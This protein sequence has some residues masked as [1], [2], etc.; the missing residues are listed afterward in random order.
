MIRVRRVQE[1][2]REKLWKLI[3]QIEIGLTSL[4][5]DRQALDDKISRALQCFAHSSVENSP[6]YFFVMEDCEN[7]ELMGCSAIEGNVGYDDA[8]YSYKLSKLSRYNKPLNIH[9]TTPVLF[10]V[11]DYQGAT[12]L[13]AFFIAKPYRHQHY[14]KLLSWSR[15][16]FMAENPTM[17]PDPIIAELRGVSDES[18]SSPFWKSLGEKFFDM[19]FQLADFLSGIGR[20]HFIADLMPK[21]PIY[22]KLLT[23]EAQDVI[24]KS[25]P[26]TQAAENLLQ[27]QGFY[28]NGYIDI[29]D[30]GPVYE[31]T[32]S[33]IKLVQESCC[34]IVSEIRADIVDS[35]PYLLAKINPDFFVCAGDAIITPDN[36]LIITK[37]AAATLNAK[38]GDTLRIALLT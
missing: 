27:E 21:H 6:Y 14:G 36:Q 12:E 3:Q 9:Q 26:R 18:G 15:F 34:F 13:R 30:G 4:P 16:L 37:K 35:P 29:F 20:K 23:Q 1:R 19:D 22:V 5:P 11:N 33:A 8:F 28:F 32:L 25:H 7:G 10:L 17:F 31:T 38:V 2:D 24:G